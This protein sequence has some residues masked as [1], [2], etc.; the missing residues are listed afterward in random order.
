[1]YHSIAHN[2]VR[3]AALGGPSCGVSCDGLGRTVAAVYVC[4]TVLSRQL[5]QQCLRVLE[6]SGVKPLG[7]P[8]VDWRQEVI[9]F[10]A[11]AL[12]LPEPSE[13]GGSTEFQDLACWL[14]ELCPGLD[15]SKFPL[16]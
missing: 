8:A 10:L 1:M 5:L 15:G 11:F 9:G 12:L 4:T 7:E 13:A 3:K 2:P 14:C 6:V 16:P